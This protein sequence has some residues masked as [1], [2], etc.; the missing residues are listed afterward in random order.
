MTA[1][2]STCARERGLND[3]RS[4]TIGVEKW[5][6]NPGPGWFLLHQLREDRAMEEAAFELVIDG[7]LGF[8][9]EWRR[10][11]EGTVGTKGVQNL[12]CRMGVM[13]GAS[14]LLRESDWAGWEG[15][16]LWMALGVYWTS[17]GWP[18]WVLKQDSSDD[19]T[20][21]FRKLGMEIRQ[22][23]FYAGSVKMILH[24]C[25]CAKLLQPCLIPCDSMDCSRPGSSV[26]G[27][28]QATVLEWGCHA[29]P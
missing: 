7:C 2:L 15:E 16:G 11:W 1:G 3:D 14:C 28:L 22:E 23:A 4:W 17:H 26:H 29:L 13:T 5:Q 20:F 21:W 12:L 9:R 10:R 6:A 18:L 27:I 19:G 25:V 8:Y 24:M